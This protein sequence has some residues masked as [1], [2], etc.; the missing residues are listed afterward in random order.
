MEEPA[1]LV[2]PR[3][4][5][6]SSIF[7]SSP[8]WAFRLSSFRVSLAAASSRVL[9]R[10]KTS[11]VSFMAWSVAVSH[12]EPSVILRPNWLILTFSVL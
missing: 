2:L 8:A 7:S 5:R 4:I 10:M 11:T 6:L 9:A 3:A 12:E 1:L